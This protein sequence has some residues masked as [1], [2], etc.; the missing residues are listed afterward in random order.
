MGN[1]VVVLTM[2]RV[3]LV[4]PDLIAG[5]VNEFTLLTMTPSFSVKL[6]LIPLDEVDMGEGD[7]VGVDTDVS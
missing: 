4:V 6:P 7:E 1:E 2:G 3:C 5:F